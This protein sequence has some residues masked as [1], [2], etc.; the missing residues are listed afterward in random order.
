MLRALQEALDILPVLHD[1]YPAANEDHG[2]GG[3]AIFAW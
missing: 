3:V 2:P 1:D